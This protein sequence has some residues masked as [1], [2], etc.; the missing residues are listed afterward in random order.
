MKD[1]LSICELVWEEFK[2][3]KYCRGRKVYECMNQLSRTKFCI[4]TGCIRDEEKGNPV[5]M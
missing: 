1:K 4:K 3:S 2:M 5:E